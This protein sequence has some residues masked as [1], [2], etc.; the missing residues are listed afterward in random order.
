MNTKLWGSVW[1]ITQVIKTFQ[2]TS[3]MVLLSPSPSPTTLDPQTCM[4][5]PKSPTTHVP[6]GLT[7]MLRLLMSLCTTAGLWQPA[8]EPACMRKFSEL[9]YISGL[10]FVK[11]TATSLQLEIR[12]HTHPVGTNTQSATE[13]IFTLIWLAHAFG[14]RL[15]CR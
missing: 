3:V 15:L 4:A 12:L 10:H 13:A 2:L 1:Y 9:M 6:S 7:R 14:T 8:D 5:K 11:V